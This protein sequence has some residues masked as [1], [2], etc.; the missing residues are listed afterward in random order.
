MPKALRD[1]P[2]KY[3][4]LRK[5]LR[6]FRGVVEKRKRGKGSERMFYHPNINGRPAFYPV[7]CHG[8]GDELSKEV[9]R[10]ARQ[11]F[12]ISIEEFYSR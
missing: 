1:K 3:R 8:E 6:D 4:E 7:K 10:A 2:L 9:V 12:N 11:R 5:K